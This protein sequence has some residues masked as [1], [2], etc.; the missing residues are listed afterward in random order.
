MVEGGKGYG[1]LTVREGIENPL[2]SRFLALAL[3]HQSV[4]IVGLVSTPIAS[5]DIGMYFEILPELWFLVIKRIRE[6]SR[7][8]PKL[9][10]SQL[11]V[12]F[13]DRGTL[14]L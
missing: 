2:H 13:R 14:T 11:A 5:K 4:G 8:I 1:L 7:V 3:D 9:A 6:A 10:I 12:M